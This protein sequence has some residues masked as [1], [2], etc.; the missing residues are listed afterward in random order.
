MEDVKMCPESFWENSQRGWEIT[1]TAASELNHKQ[2][3]R[4]PLSAPG[5]AELCYAR[6]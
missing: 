1:A 3:Q 5:A 6:L 2:E 4:Q